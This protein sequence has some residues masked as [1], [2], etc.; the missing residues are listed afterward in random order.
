MKKKSV[1]LLLSLVLSILS[2][3]LSFSHVFA[4]GASLAYDGLDWGDLNEFL[5]EYEEIISQSQEGPN[6]NLHEWKLAVY[7]YVFHLKERSGYKAA[8]EFF[9]NLAMRMGNQRIEGTASRIGDT[10]ID[11]S[12]HYSPRS[13]AGFFYENGRRFMPLVIND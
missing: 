11:F 3:G 13:V 1:K 10:Y 6:I 9:R 12:I 5:N 7:N 4:V 2:L 8:G